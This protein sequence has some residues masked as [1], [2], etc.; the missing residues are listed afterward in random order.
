MAFLAPRYPSKT[1][2]LLKYLR[3]NMLGLIFWWSLRW[4]LR[5]QVK[6]FCYARE[7]KCHHKSSLKTDIACCTIFITV[8]KIALM[9]NDRV[10]L[11]ILSYI[12]TF[13]A[14]FN[15]IRGEIKDMDTLKNEWINHV[16]FDFIIVQDC[17]AFSSQFFMSL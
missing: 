12:L 13:F 4:I 16:M 5:Y 3:K 11:Y 17:S 7:Q 1:N 15:K 2:F 9:D 14:T 10:M 8:G 6:T